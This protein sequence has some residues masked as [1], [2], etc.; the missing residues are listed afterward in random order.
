MSRSK[1]IK[2]SISGIATVHG[3]IKEKFDDIKDLYNNDI[4]KINKLK[5]KIGLNQIYKAGKFTTSYDLCLSATKLLI[6]ELRFNTKEIDA[7]IFVTQTPDYFLPGN[8]NLI[9]RDLDLNRDCACFDLSQGCSG[10]IY[11]L[12]MAHMLIEINSAEKVLL[13]AGDT[14]S[15]NVNLFDTSSRPLFGDAGTATLVEKHKEIQDSFFTVNTDG[16]GYDSIIIPA[17]GFRKRI[18]KLW[19]RI[20]IYS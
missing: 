20:K 12:W 8:S 9:H 7:V 1:L 11:G 19:F 3:Q 4:D 16:S 10:Y 15:K 5:D 13:L 6:K 17:G 2:S 14:M 18:N